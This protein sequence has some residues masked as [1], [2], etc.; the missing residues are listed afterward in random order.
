MMSR[1]IGMRQNLLKLL[2]PA[3]ML[4]GTEGTRN[5]RLSFNSVDITLVKVRSSPLPKG[6][7][8]GSEN[9][10]DGLG[11]SRT[12]NAEDPPQSG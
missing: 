8:N 1:N 9:N 10:G 2:N 11:P 4:R 6:A 3:S 7:A 5:R 12:L